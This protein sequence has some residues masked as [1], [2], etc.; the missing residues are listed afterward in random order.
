MADNIAFVI[1]T[2]FACI[3]FL[4]TIQVLY[5][6]KRLVVSAL[7][8][9]V[10]ICAPMTLYKPVMNSLGY[11][12]KTAETES[13]RMLMYVVDSEQKW[14]HIWTY[15]AEVDEPRSFKIPYTKQDEKKLAEGKKKAEEGVPQQVVIPGASFTSGGGSAEG[16]LVVE[17][18]PDR[19]ETK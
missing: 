16:E 4:F 10:T 3:G 9:A 1:V 8:I 2:A 12:I 15:D 19:G 18:L 6:P 17:D 13:A 11:S 14:I 5:P 7:F